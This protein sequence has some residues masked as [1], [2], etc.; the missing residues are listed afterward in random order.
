MRK[1]N[2]KQVRSTLANTG[3][4]GNKVLAS[5]I[6]DRI[7]SLLGKKGGEWIG[8]MSELDIALRSVVRAKPPAN[9]PSSPS[10]MRKVVN[11]TIYSLR[12]SGV[13]V[14]FTRTTDHMRKRVVEFVQR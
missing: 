6:R 9:W 4:Y 13:K 1:T 8:S 2:N 3:I 7:T 10:V 14:N 5:V 12:R 11:N